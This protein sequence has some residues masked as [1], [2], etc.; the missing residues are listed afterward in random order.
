VVA[1]KLKKE[2]TK[3]ASMAGKESNKTPIKEIIESRSSSIEDD[4]EDQVPD[5]PSVSTPAKSDMDSVK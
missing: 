4:Q 3:K 1:E 5:L 2:E